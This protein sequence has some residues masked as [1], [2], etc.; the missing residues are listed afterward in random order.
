MKDLIIIGAGPAGLAAAIYGL[1]AGLN[2]A[3]LEKFSPGGQVINTWEV[4]NYPGFAEPV[5]GVALMA[6]MEAQ[7][8]RLGAD[9]TGGEVEQVEKT[10]DF[11]SLKMSDGPA[12]E[13]KAVIAAT[14]ASLRKLGVPGEKD[15]T[16]RGVSYCATCDAAFFRNKTVAVVGGGDTALEEAIFL[17]RFAEKIYLMHRRDRFRGSK[18]L[19]ERILS[20]NK[21]EPLYDTVVE[22]INGSAVVESARVKN[23]VSGKVSDITLQ[24][25]FIFIGFDPNAGYLPR[26]VLNGKGEASVDM[27]MRTPIPG[28]FAAG[29]IRSDSRRQIVTACADGATAAMESYDYIES[30]VKIT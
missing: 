30:S 20:S 21:V 28:L 22:S 12:L 2:L 4:E 3:V 25:I 9:I 16:G 8:R 23:K 29:D 17:T 6:A 11:F 19:Q 10:G 5:S 18:I 14:G 24:G 27:R 7:A 13:T 26:T 1:R 15:F